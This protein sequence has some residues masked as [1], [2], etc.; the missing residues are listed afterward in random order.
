MDYSLLINVESAEAETKLNQRA[1]SR[2]SNKNFFISKGKNYYY[3]LGII[4][5]L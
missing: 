2:E 1:Y 4:D 3:Q 5:F